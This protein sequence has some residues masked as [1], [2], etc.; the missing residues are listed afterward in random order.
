MNLP[1]PMP[2]PRNS[3]EAWALAAAAFVVALAVRFAFSGI[4]E[5][6]I[7]YFTFIPAIVIAAYF[8]GLWPAILVAAASTLSGWY[9][10]LIPVWS[11][12]MSPSGILSMSFFIGVSAINILVVYVMRMAL[13]RL[14]AESARSAA[15]A[16]QREILFRELQHRVSNNLAVVSALL[17]LE[18]A[19][20]E[21]EKARQALTEA[22]TRLALIAKI[23]RRLHD[24]VG[25]QLRFGP[26]VEDLCRDVLEASGAGNIVCLVS[27][28][29]AVIP[30]EKVVPI[31]LIVTELISNA[32]EHGFAGRESGTIRI[33]LTP[34]GAEHL[35]TIA[36]DGQGLPADF[37]LDEAGM[38]LRIVQSLAH[39]IEGRFAVESENGT[40]W[41]LVFPSSIPAAV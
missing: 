5:V 30:S 33:D 4:A 1:R 24:P 13:E 26:F 25:A 16:E 41:R 2:L 27:A 36:D 8:S 19:G 29:E 3:P 6:G 35:L 7:P 17:N 28:A 9:F 11:W 37:T 22:S 18:R 15:L 10:F 31:A 39:Q 40:T 32:L 12:G 20:V 21:D 38:G 14:D 34:V 23:H